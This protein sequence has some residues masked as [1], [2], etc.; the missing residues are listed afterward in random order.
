[1]RVHNETSP[2]RSHRAVC[3]QAP[4]RRQKGSS[5]QEATGPLGIEH[6]NAGGPA[7]AHQRHGVVSPPSRRRAR[8]ATTKQLQGKSTS[9][10]VIGRPCHHSSTPG[11]PCDENNRSQQRQWQFRESSY[12]AFHKRSE[13]KTT[14]SIRQWHYHCLVAVLGAVLYRRGLKTQSPRDVTSYLVSIN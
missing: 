11:A 5:A 10:N 4:P 9:S 2:R 12:C 14:S 3:H 1:M 6:V 13:H 7:T 8:H